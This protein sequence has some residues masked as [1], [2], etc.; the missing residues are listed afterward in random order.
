MSRNNGVWRARR[1]QEEHHVNRRPC[2][3]TLYRLYLLQGNKWKPFC[4]FVEAQ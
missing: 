4:P 1:I 2:R 3:L